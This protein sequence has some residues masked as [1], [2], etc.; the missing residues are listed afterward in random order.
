MGTGERKVVSWCRAK[1]MAGGTGIAVGLNKGHSTT[2]REVASRPVSRKGRLNK[3]VKVIRDIAREVMG[4]APYEK[5]MLELAK[6]GK[7]KRALKLASKKLGS[8]KRAK[9]KKDDLSAWS[10]RK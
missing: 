9:K 2:K 6:V 4:L 7:D 5:R 3:R 10:R 8:L 1:A